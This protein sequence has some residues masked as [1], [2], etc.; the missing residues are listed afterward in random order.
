MKA[1]ERTDEHHILK[2]KLF[3]S[4]TNKSIYKTV[5]F[6]DSITRRWEDNIELWNEY[7][8]LCSPLNMGVGMDTLE[9]MLWRIQNGQLDG[10]SPSVII[11]LAG[12]N[13]ITQSTVSY[14]ADGI[15][16]IAKEIQKKCSNAKLI[17]CGLLPRL[18]DDAGIDCTKKIGEVNSL[19]EPL[20]KKEGLSY[21]YY[22]DK[23]L[24][25]DGSIDR[26][27]QEDGLHLNAEGYK[28][29]GPILKK[30][31]EDLL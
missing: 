9:N 4:L 30:I 15:I 7:F 28:I 25:K 18:Q 3:M 13:N 8:R 20:C 23:L 19:L 29:A 11:L 31:I 26:R 17:V 21:I 14:I 12:T 5:F 24:A 27:V 1:I 10:L 2:H 22:G 6:G 16:E